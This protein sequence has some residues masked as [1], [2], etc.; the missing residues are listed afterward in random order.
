MRF[1]DTSALIPLVIEQELS[2]QVEPLYRDDPMVVLWWG[3]PVEWTSALARLQRE[4]ALAKE[5][6]DWAR[7]TLAALHETAVEVQPMEDVRARAKRL[8]V[9]HSLR[10]ADSLQLSAALHWCRERTEH[11]SFV[12]LDSRLREA[13][14][15]EGFEVH[16]ESLT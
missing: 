4:D 3:T 1:W 7:G 6:I 2:P 11:S 9:L 14:Q 13:A 12:S 5:E 10:A 15:R 16:P 8:L